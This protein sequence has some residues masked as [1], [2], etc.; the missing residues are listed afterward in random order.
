MR[1]VF[2]DAYAILCSDFLFKSICCGY[3]F[4]L[5]RLET[6]SRGNSNEYH[7]ICFYKEFDKS[8]L[9]VI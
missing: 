5:P 8:T 1:S 6:T 7:N 4:E 3:L 2:N 9:A